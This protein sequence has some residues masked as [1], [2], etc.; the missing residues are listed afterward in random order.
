MPDAPPYP[1]A[2]GHAFGLTRYGS[3][4]I[5]DG[6]TDRKDQAAIRQWGATYKGRMRRPRFEP[7]GQFDGTMQRAVA[8]VQKIA[9]LPVT[10]LLGPDE[11]ALPWT[12]DPPKGAYVRPGGE[13][14]EKQKAQHRANVRDYWRRYSK[15]DIHPGTDPTAPPWFPG[16]PFGQKEYGEHVKPVQ[17]FFGMKENGRF[18]RL[19]A[20]H[21]RG[22]QRTRG[23]PISG[24]VDARTASYM[25]AEIDNPLPL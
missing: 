6:K 17:H 23:L 5:H 18:C 22:F 1:L 12:L 24:I 15:F 11:W 16:R 25:Q 14:A 20:Q 10:G 21:V 4:M 19:T 13:H 9:G 2:Q 8:E 3:V 7:T